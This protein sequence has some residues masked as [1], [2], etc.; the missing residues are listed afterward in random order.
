MLFNCV[1]KSLWEKN[2][3]NHGNFILINYSGHINNR[4][5]PMLGRRGSCFRRDEP[6]L[7]LH[8]ISTWR[9]VFFS[10]IKMSLSKRCIFKGTC[11]K[12]KTLTNFSNIYKHIWHTRPLQCSHR[13]QNTP[14]RKIACQSFFITN[15]KGSRY[16]ND[17]CCVLTSQQYQ[18]CTWVGLHYI[19]KLQN[20][21]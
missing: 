12:I 9:Y 2:Q 16:C 14:G 18:Y 17:R 15:L 13:S 11:C 21:L 19:Q 7:F 5:S 1:G 6:L 10:S 8:R 20:F 3:K 4:P